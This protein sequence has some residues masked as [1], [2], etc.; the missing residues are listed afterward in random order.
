MDLNRDRILPVL[1]KTYGKA[2]SRRWFQ[3]WR[4]FFMACA[5]LFGFNNGKEWPV[6]HY[7]LG[8]KSWSRLRANYGL[9]WNPERG[10]HRISPEQKGN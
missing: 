10:S 8:R 2:E 3:R 9:L 7:L 4:M 5:E 6:S 1:E